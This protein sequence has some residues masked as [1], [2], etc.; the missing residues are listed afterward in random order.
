MTQKVI[1]F[2]F[3]GTIADTQE[4]FINILN[5]L[6]PEFGYQPTTPVEVSQLRHLSSREIIKRSQIPLVKIP[7]LLRKAKVELGKE[8][9]TISPITGMPE[10]LLELQNQGH[11]LGIVTSNVQE[12]VVGFLGKNSCQE[13]FEFI[14]HGTSLFGKHKIINRVIRDRHLS[15]NNVFYVGDETRDVQAAQKSGIK[16]IAVSWGF[17]S[18]EILATYSPDFLINTPQELIPILGRL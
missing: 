12:N 15:P 9:A 2:D 16:M 10:T 14:Y 8:I 3:D 1:I 11:Y 4:A 6:S 7:F 13:M 5:R 17:N 18:Q